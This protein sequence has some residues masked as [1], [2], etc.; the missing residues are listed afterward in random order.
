MMRRRSLLCALAVGLASVSCASAGGGG[1]GSVQRPGT[2]LPA[3]FVMDP[4][5]PVAAT[6]TLPGSGCRSP[7]FDPRDGTRATMVRST[8]TIADYA[9]PAGRYGVGEREL[10]RLECNTGRPVGIVRR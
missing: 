1:M 7:L 4:Q 9:V 8:V 5:Q 10:L 6:D 3:R 2:D